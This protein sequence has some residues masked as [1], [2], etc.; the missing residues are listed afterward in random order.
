MVPS[1]F[2]SQRPNSS[3][4]IAGRL[5]ISASSTRAGPSGR[6]RPCSQFLSVPSGMPMLLA[7]AGCDSPVLLRIATTSGQDPTDRKLIGC[8]AEL[9][10]G[11]LV[12][13][14]AWSSIRSGHWRPAGSRS[15]P[16]SPPMMRRSTASPGPQHR[17]CVRLRDR[18]RR[19]RRD[20]DRRRRQPFTDPIRSRVRET[21]RRL[22]DT[23]LERSHEQAP[24]VPRRPQAS[25]RDALSDRDRPHA[26]APADH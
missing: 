19:K 21:L 18:S 3:W 13:P 23:S 6:R 17:R 2:P 11:D 20:D 26:L 24:V 4:T 16:K 7:K 9:D 8:C 25:Q 22:S 10:S 5:S 15:R 12:N 14:M 1:P